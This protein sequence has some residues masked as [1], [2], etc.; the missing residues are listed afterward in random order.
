MIHIY[1]TIQ[2]L[3][4]A[5][6]SELAR[7]SSEAITNRGRFMLALSGGSTPCT[8]YE[9]LAK[10][11]RDSID[12][13]DVHIFWG[14]E[15]YIPHDNPESNYFLAKKSFLD[16]INIPSENIHPIPTLYSN[17]EEAARTYDRELTDIFGGIKPAFDLI[18]LGLGSDGHTASLFPSLKFEKDDSRNVIVT[19]SPAGPRIRI[20]LTMNAINRARNIFFLVEGKKKAGILK[21]VLNSTKEKEPHFPAS[22]IKPN[23]TLTWFVNQ[24]AAKEWEQ[25]L[26]K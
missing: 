6:A 22:R 7:L 11:Y 13:Q 23:G 17:P 15:R 3:S 12:W 8:L 2:S 18:L 19:E 9:V 21:N 14:D 25:P 16:Y 4:E 20:S 26:K 10:H 24:A 5:A 1:P